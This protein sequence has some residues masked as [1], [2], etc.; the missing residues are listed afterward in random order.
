MM[1]ARERDF[2]FYFCCTA[3][4]SLRLIVSSQERREKGP[5]SVVQRFSLPNFAYL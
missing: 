5:L 3:Q 1:A 4:N 2:Y